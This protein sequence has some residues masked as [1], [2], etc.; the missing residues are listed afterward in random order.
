MIEVDFPL[1]RG[2]EAWRNE[3]G[4]IGNQSQ[5]PDANSCLFPIPYSDT[6]G[7]EDKI[8]YSQYLKSSNNLFIYMTLKVTVFS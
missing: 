1:Y 8:S 2:M 4:H 3:W 6:D 7:K 5:N